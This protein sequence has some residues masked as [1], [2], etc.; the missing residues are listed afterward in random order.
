MKA[1]D[2]RKSILQAAVQGKL[3]PQNPHDEPAAVLLEK[4]S[5][6]RE[7]LLKNGYPNSIEAKN[8]LNKQKKQAIPK[9]LSD[10]PCGWTW[11]TLMSCATLVVDCHNKTAPYVEKGTHLIRTSNI[12][13]GNIVYAGM[14]YVT[15][16]TKH[17]WSS[18]CLP[19]AGDILITREAPMGEICILPLG[20]DFCLG[21]RIM[22]VRINHEMVSSE[23]LYYFLRNP[24]FMEYV[25]DKPVGLTVKHL[26]VNGVETMLIALPPLA[27]QIRIATK[28]NG[29]MTLCDELETAEKELDSLESQ[30]AEYLPKSILQA[31]V[32]GKLVPQNI[33]DESADKLLE[34]IRT[35]KAKLVKT[36]KLKKEKPLPPITEE[37]I[38]YDLPDGWTW[39]RLGDVCQVNPRNKLADEI[40][41]S[42]VPMT[43]ISSDFFGGHQQEQRVWGEVKSGFTH[44]AEGDIVIAKITPCFQNKKS[45]IMRGL[46]NGFGAGTTELHVLRPIHVLTEYIL[47]YAKSPEFL[48]DGVKNM[49]GTA[50]QQRVPTEFVRSAIIPLPPLA[51]QQRIVAKVNELMA[52]CDALKAAHDTPV[53]APIAATVI[54][55]PHQEEEP[56]MLMAA[57]GAMPK[58]PSKALQDARNK[59]FED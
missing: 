25:Q 35:E 26:R 36:G 7:K 24:N 22:L 50:G 47:L 42:F 30:F 17:K 57:R 58:A 3:V 6:F 18:R 21:Q 15:Q 34:R 49:T 28:V 53:G 41:V 48:D 14:K 54:P 2:L 38:P 19:Q 55:F 31:A 8:Q 45:C 44:F 33:H 13:D 16:E 1:A 52:L 12:R 9:D 27:E 4:I 5:I 40:H 32:Q 20:G 51:E 39:C 29:L 23:Y 10:L 46:K 43:L 56:E 59:L 37:E 11:C